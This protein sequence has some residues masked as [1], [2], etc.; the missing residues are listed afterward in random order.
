MAIRTPGLPVTVIQVVAHSHPPLLVD[1][2][3]HPL[4]LSVIASTQDPLVK[5]QPRIGIIFRG[6]GTV[7][8][9]EEH[10]HW[11]QKALR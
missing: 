2:L 10:T 8:S 3:T 9:K 5:V 7:A 1:T 6:A 4:L 11:L